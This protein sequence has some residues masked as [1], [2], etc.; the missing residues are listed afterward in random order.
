VQEREYAL[1][2]KLFHTQHRVAPQELKH[3]LQH[4][5]GKVA[6]LQGKYAMERMIIVTVPL[7]IQVD[8][9][10]RFTGTGVAHAG[11]IFIKIPHQLHQIMYT[12]E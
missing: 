10:F 11:S 8:V 1:L 2:V 12:K 9:E 5:H 3:V 6:Y 4:V 7:I